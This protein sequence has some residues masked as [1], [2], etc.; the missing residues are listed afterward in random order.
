MK[1]FNY[2]IFLML[3]MGIWACT[4]TQQT[5]DTEP[6]LEGVKGRQGDTGQQDDPNSK[7]NGNPMKMVIAI[8]YPVGY[9][10]QLFQQEFGA[11]VGLSEPDDVLGCLGSP[12]ARELWLVDYL[13][14]EDFELLLVLYFDTVVDPKTTSNGTGASQPYSAHKR[15]PNKTEGES[16]ILIWY[17]GVCN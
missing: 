4:D 1:K 11:V 12:N 7:M 5:V 15:K 10:R 9:N 2:V 3:I 13:S 6:V 17:N 16:T 8:E 14:Q